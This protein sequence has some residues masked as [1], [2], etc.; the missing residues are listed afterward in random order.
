MSSKT[1]RENIQR[2]AEK[3][4][5]V[6]QLDAA[7]NPDP[8]LAKTGLGSTGQQQTAAGGCIASPLT[9]PDYTTRTW[10]DAREVTTT[11]GIFTFI[12]EDLASVD[13]LD[14]NNAAVQLIFAEFAT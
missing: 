8:I 1:T 10:H 14:A 3:R 13:M 12:V 2:L 4:P 6:T 9:E 5:G 11:D 7:A